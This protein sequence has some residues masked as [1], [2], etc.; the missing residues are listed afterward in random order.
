MRPTLTNRWFFA[1][2]LLLLAPGCGE[3]N[4]GTKPTPLP[5]PRTWRVPADAPTIQAGVNLASPGDT[6]LV[7]AGTYLDCTQLDLAGNPCCI[8]M[9]S[10]VCLRGD[11]ADP[12][13]VVVDARSAGRVIYCNG[14]DST[15]S[16][17]GLTLRGGSMPGDKDTPGENFGGGMY[18]YES[19]VRITDCAVS[20]NVSAVGGG[21]Y[22]VSSSPILTGCRFSGNTAYETGGGGGIACISSSPVLVDCLFFDNHAFV[23]G[24]MHVSGSSAPTLSHCSFLDNRAD[25]ACGIYC[26]E[27]SM[28]LSY[29]TFCGNGGAECGGGALFG[30]CSPN[31]S[32]CT[33]V[34]NSAEDGGAMYFDAGSATITTTIIAF[35]HGG[36]PIHCEDE[37][38]IPSLT[39]CDLYDNDGG[40]WAGYIAEQRHGYGNIS[41]DPLFCDAD[42][43]DFHL[44]SDSPCS[45]NI[46]CD[47]I[48]AWEVSCPD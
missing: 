46:I 27:S 25:Y 15:A 34:G 26:V 13:E 29:S 40:D 16:I 32:H 33:F 8:I 11:T 47:L 48:G 31:L 21:M 44:R 3:E 41:Q 6:V 2:L 19:S 37:A 14:V 38:S 42:N 28:D 22:C 18:C 43:R 39:C 12:A 20:D 5:V 7:S 45:P 17:E 9:K 30:L 35:N 24:G 1:W 4:G 36:C 23:G 10:G